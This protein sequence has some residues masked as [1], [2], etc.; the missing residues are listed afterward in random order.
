MF[1]FWFF[2]VCFDAFTGYVVVFRGLKITVRAG[3]R[4][5]KEI[6]KK[7]NNWFIISKKQTLLKRKLLL[8]LLLF[9]EFVNVLS[10]PPHLIC[11]FLFIVFFCY[12]LGVCVCVSFFL[13]INIVTLELSINKT[14]IKLE[15]NFRFRYIFVRFIM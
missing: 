1:C 15:T 2:F 11:W 13:I 4:Q 8:L 5:K 3:W 7:I 12:F 14:K 10:L 9:F 6:E